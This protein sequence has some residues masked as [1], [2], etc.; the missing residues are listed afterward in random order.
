VLVG[1]WLIARARSVV[2]PVAAAGDKAGG[3]G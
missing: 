1:I 3:K 2:E